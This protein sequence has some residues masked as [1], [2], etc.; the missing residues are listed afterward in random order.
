MGKEH[1]ARLPAVPNPHRM[2]E[3]AGHKGIPVG[4]EL[5]AEYVRLM[6]CKRQKLPVYSVGSQSVRC[7]HMSTHLPYS[8]SHMRTVVSSL[9]EA[10]KEPSAPQLTSFTPRVCPTN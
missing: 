10:K 2:V 3:G 7:S 6:A 5:H 9:A 4:A 1:R 8:T